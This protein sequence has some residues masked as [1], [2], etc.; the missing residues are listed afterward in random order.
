M[1]ST[2]TVNS[3]R[4]AIERKVTQYD[5]QALANS[6]VVETSPKN[7]LSLFASSKS[8]GLLWVMVFDASALPG[9]GALPVMQPLQIAAA[10]QAFLSVTDDSGQGL[11][12]LELAHG[13]VWAASSTQATLTVDTTS[14][15][16][17]T[18]R[19]N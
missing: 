8:A 6:E 4:Q 16:W 19:Y 7:L 10:G 12:G 5:S 1:P 17:V 9:N 14:S 3:L 11:C 13:L 18:I 2:K 15:V